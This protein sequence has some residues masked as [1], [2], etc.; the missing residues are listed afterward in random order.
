MSRTK[1]IIH[2]TY[3]VALEA[4]TSPPRGRLE[5]Q[6]PSHHPYPVSPS[7]RRQRGALGCTRGPLGW[8]QWGT[9]V[10]RASRSVRG[11][12]WRFCDVEFG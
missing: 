11:I 1:N 8:R 12:S 2:M 10:A 4:P 6:N 5:R 7:R 9:L 3:V